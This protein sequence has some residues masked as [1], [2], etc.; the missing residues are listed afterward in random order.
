MYQI[1]DV[2]HNFTNKNTYDVIKVDGER[3]SLKYRKADDH[4]IVIRERDYAKYKI[5]GSPIQT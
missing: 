1:G 5:V 3:V 4:V 2:V